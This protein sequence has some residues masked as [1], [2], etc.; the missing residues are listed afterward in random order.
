MLKIP[1]SY[2]QG[3]SKESADERGGKT[4]FATKW[5]ME[6][7]EKSGDSPSKGLKRNCR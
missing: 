1:T 3:I 5:K 4:K 6:I 7:A 2:I